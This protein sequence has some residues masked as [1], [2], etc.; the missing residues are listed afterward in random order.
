MPNGMHAVSFQK[1]SLDV[2]L[3]NYITKILII[4]ANLKNL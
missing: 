1:S 2:N 3:N 4:C